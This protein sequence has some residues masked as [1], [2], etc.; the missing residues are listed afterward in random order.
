MAA[1]KLVDELADPAI[2]SGQDYCRGWADAAPIFFNHGVEVGR[3][4]QAELMACE[5]AEV[6][7]EVRGTARDL[8]LE[9]RRWGGRRKDFG[10]PRP[11]DHRGGPVEPW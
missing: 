1:A 5:W 4:Q 7:R 11:S 2:R 3:R 6:A 9:L 8:D 10:R